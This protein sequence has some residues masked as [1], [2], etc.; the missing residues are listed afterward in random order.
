MRRTFA[1][2]MMLA[3]L[4]ALACSRAD[5]PA[6]F[7][8]RDSA[9]VAVA[10]SLAPQWTSGS[11]WSLAE[12]PHLEIGAAD[13]PGHD[14]HEVSG[15]VRLTDGRIAIANA[16]SREIRVFTPE[17]VLAETFGGA[18]AGPGEFRSLSRIFLLP[19]DSLLIT[20]QSLDRLTVFTD[21][22]RVARTAQLAASPDGGLPY[23]TTRLADGSLLA[24]PGFTFSSRSEPGVHRDTIPIMRYTG[25]GAFA[26]EVGR[27]PDSERFVYNDGGN[28]FGG[29]RVWGLKTH[30][31]AAG[32]VLIIA[33]S[34]DH[35]YHAHDSAGQ[36]L[37]IVRARRPLRP[38]TD[39]DIAVLREPAEGEDP[40]SAVFWR[41]MLDAMEF[42]THFPAY[43]GILTEADGHVWLREYAWPEHEAVRQEW[44]VFDPDG[45][46]LGAVTMPDGFAPL[47]VAGDEVLGLYR[48]DMDVEHLRAYRLRR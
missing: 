37:R 13:E 11:G 41:R 45:R 19:G 29:E 26:A 17:G 10:E 2:A 33:R 21:S 3:G 18:G 40:A 35:E 30:I 32:D 46:W 44:Q 9:G 4:P 22:G 14:L 24:R 23:V 39:A 38:V 36:L 34:A 6:E 43:A 12:S 16:G 1:A 42:P 5:A 28:V 48:D 8:V 20:D 25:D 47:S 31:A 15:A 7:S 27:F